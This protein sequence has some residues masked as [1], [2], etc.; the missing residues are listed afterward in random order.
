MNKQLWELYKESERGKNCIA[1]FSLETNDSYESVN[2]IAE[3]LSQPQF[4][5]NE[6]NGSYINWWIDVFLCNIQER[7][8]R[9]ETWTRESFA[10]LVEN[11][12]IFLPIAH[13]DGTISFDRSESKTFLKKNMFRDKAAFTHCFSL[14][15]YYTEKNFKF[16]PLLL[17]YRF[18][19]FQKNCDSLRIEI[20]DI[21]RTKNYKE[22]C[23]YYWDINV[24]LN[25]FQLEN[26]LSD[27]E[28]CACL[29]DFSML[30]YEE[31][32]TTQLPKPTNVWFTGGSGKEDFALL[33]S[34]GKDFG[35]NK[36]C[37]WACNEKTRRGDIIVMYC[38]T[39]RSYIHSIWRAS[40]NGIFNPFD[41]Y[42]CR[43]NLCDGIL[44]PPISI[45]GLKNDKY[46]SQIPIVRSNLQGLN[47]VELSAKD[48]SELLRMIEEKGGDISQ[49]PKLFEGE[50]VDFGKINVEKDVEE[51]I[52]IPILQRLGYNESDWTRQLS[53]KAGR[54]E[55]AIPDFV[56]FPQGE[57]HFESAPMVI[58]AKFDMSS[59]QELQNAFKQGLSYARLLH[60]S[61]M[62]ICDKERLVLYKIDLN[63]SADYNAP[64][65]E[66][67]WASIYSNSEIGAELNHLIGREAIESINS[68]IS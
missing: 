31:S 5:N 25:E 55:K 64:I 16:K 37:L 57:R 60:A 34:L 53:L 62:G 56:F 24:V 68:R 35:I 12:D 15:L 61:I 20:P 51:N 47:G 44:T 4:G 33:D 2:K 39:P 36:S 7:G 32:T 48:Y 26:K 65:F 45:K 54:K 13:D 67:H 6:L 21:P 22:Y 30:L 18:D 23:L 42:H 19:I 58:E 1:L 59:M 8:L 29:Y 41:C 66:D 9:P 28:M 14:A 10:K 27:A 17:P 3:F 40:S 63:G 11:L 43:T 38:K 50:S 46:M 52:L 49:Y